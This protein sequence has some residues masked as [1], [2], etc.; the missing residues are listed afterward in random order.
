MRKT[1]NLGISD[2]KH[3]MLLNPFTSRVHHLKSTLSK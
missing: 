3:E 1:D 2:L